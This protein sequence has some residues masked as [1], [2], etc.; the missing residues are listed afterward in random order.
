[1]SS[2][3]TIKETLNYFK[4][5][6]LLTIFFFGI[7]SGFPWVLIGS[8]MTGW[9]KDEGLSRSSIG[10]FGLIFACYSINFLWSPLADRVKLPFITAKMGM[11]RSWIIVTQAI[12]VFATIQLSFLDVASQLNLMALFGLILAFSGSTQDIAIDAYRIDSL[13]N[14]GNSDNNIMAAGSAMA[15]AGW[16]TGYAGLGSIPFILV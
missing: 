9:L 16:W 7:A 6:R 3:N 5:K 4:D 14:S 15:T 11:R 2:P 8:A 1:M 10:L 13:A 12:I